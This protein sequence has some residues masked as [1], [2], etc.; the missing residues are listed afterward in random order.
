MLTS[1]EC[2]RSNL[3]LIRVSSLIYATNQ[4]NSIAVNIQKHRDFSIRLNPRLLGE[5]Y[6]FAQQPFI[7]RIEVIA[8]KEEKDAPS[9]LISYC[10]PLN[11]VYL[12]GLLSPLEVAAEPIKKRGD[13]PNWAI[14]Q[15]F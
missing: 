1:A 13:D 15:N 6:P 10:L 8:S 11:L 12:S 5:L 7:I 9:S 2:P 14:P 4:I 3:Y